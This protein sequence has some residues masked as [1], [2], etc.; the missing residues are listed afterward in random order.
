[1]AEKNL[2]NRENR[3]VKIKI[4]FPVHNECILL[5]MYIVSRS[6]DLF[7]KL[8]NILFESHPKRNTTEHHI[9]SFISF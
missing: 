6:E 2:G 4:F 8:F 7:D 9:Q 3:W 1:M 5:T